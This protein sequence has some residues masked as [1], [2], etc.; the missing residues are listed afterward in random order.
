MSLTKYLSPGFWWRNRGRLVQEGT[1]RSRRTWGRVTG[2]RL[3]LDENSRRIEALRNRH[4]GKR[5]V[6]VGNGPSLRVS[7]LTRLQDEITF[8]ANKIYLA[9]DQ[10][11]W[12]PTYYNVEDPL[13]IQQNYQKVNTLKGFPKLLKRYEPGYWQK[14]EWTVFYDLVVL[15]ERDFPR[16]SGN[17]H[18]GLYCGYSVCISSLQWA[19]FMGITE[20][21]LIGVD[22]NFT[23]PN[24][25]KQGMIRSEGEVNHFLPNY[26]APG[27]KWQVP[28]LEQQLAAF[29]CCRDWLG[30]RGVKVFN[31]TRGGKLEVFP[32][33]DFDDVF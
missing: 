10:T 7:D 15:P 2:G 20:I 33:V 29:T 24:A 5:A 14:D 1:L 32:R 4:A 18:A 31:A 8:A 6:I 23:V 22:F 17:P 30:P 9:F 12:R 28:A 19:W 26:R 25:D 21:Y 16:F 3:P 13:V 27:E 11:P